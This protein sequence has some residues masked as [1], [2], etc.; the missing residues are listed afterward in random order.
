MQ[1]V[2]A[3][4]ARGAA[5]P[6]L[7]GSCAYSS[8]SARACASRLSVYASVLLPSLFGALRRCC[9]DNDATLIIQLNREETSSAMPRDIE[10]RDAAVAR[11]F[12]RADAY[13]AQA[14]RHAQAMRAV[15]E[16][17]ALRACCLCG[18][19]VSSERKGDEA[20]AIERWYSAGG[21]DACLRICRRWRGACYVASARCYAYV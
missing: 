5:L 16:R 15:R 12:T 14:M 6:R 11:A 21:S 3:A 8:A 7:C 18:V 4:R 13:A 20:S 9:R 2:A 19:T 17:A 10:R 1:Q